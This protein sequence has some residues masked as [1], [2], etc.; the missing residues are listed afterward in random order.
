M[1]AEMVFRIR[2]ICSRRIG[3]QS[4]RSVAPVSNRGR[5]VGPAALA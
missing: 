1:L 2:D 5:S 4:S 3:P